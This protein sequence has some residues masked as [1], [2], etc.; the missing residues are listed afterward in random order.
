MFSLSE[1]EFGT[2]FLITV[3]QTKLPK[4]INSLIVIAVVRLN[5][6]DATLLM[7]SKISVP[8]F[9]E[10]DADLS[11]DA[12]AAI[13]LANK[14]KPTPRAAPNHNQKFI[15]SGSVFMKFITEINSNVKSL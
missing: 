5:I 2:V 13:A 8:R 4:T 1:L 10:I 15:D 12:I 14:P 3:L 11:T 7:N 6:P 9:F